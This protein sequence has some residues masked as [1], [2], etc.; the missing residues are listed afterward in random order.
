MDFGEETHTGDIG[1]KIG[2]KR[3]RKIGEKEVR[4]LGEKRRATRR[5][6]ER[7]EEEGGSGEQRRDDGR[8]AVLV[9]T[10]CISDIRVG[11]MKVR[12]RRRKKSEGA[13]SEWG[14]ERGGAPR[15]LR[16]VMRNIFRV[17]K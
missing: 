8:E 5:K 12:R 9:L 7:E 14:R 1:E 2:M 6:R 4:D 17:N 15:D 11:E 13:D 3:G 10:E 16:S